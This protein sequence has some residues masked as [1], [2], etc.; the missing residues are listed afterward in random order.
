MAENY[1]GRQDNSHN[2][3]LLI[4]NELVHVRKSSQKLILL[5]VGVQA[6]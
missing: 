5:F 2:F 3:L 1:F 4:Q 6:N